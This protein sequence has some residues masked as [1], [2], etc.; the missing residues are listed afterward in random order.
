MNKQIILFTLLSIMT[1]C[2]PSYFINYQIYTVKNDF[3]QTGNTLQYENEDCILYYNLWSEGGNPG[4]V[5][6]NKSNNNIF[7][8]MDKSFYIHNGIAYDYYKDMVVT[9]GYMS[10]YNESINING[11]I[12]YPYYSL[13]NPIDATTNFGYNTNH[14]SSITIKEQSIICIPPHSSKYIPVHYKISNGEK[15]NYE[16]D[17]DIDESPYIFRNR[18]SYMVNNNDS[19]K[20]IDNKFWVSNIIRSNSYNITPIKSVRDTHNTNIHL[21]ESPN[22]FYIK[23]YTEKGNSVKINRE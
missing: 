18:I 23:Y 17:I 8:L 4:F 11:E 19:L 1:S 7:I 21:E 5:F 10:S 16:G 3:C 14:S 22:K 15:I 6:K 20:Y 12:L 9:N 2:T 13:V